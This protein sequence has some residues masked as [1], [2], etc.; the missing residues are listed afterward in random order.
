MIVQFSIL[1][2]ISYYWHNYTT[3]RMHTCITVY[4]QLTV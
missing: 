3:A 2:I 4:E 1:N